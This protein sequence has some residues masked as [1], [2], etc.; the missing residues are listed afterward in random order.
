MDKIHG[1][2][3]IYNLFGPN[4]NRRKNN[5]KELFDF[6]KT[7]IKPPPKTQFPNWKVQPLTMWTDSI[8]PLIWMICVT[9][10]IDEMTMNFKGNHS[11][12]IRMT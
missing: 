12:K 11:D 3:F 6:Q 10:S 2:Y 9:I 7:L 8:F 5:F 4:T 1:N